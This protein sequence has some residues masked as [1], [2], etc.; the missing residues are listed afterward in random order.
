MISIETP[1]LV[2]CKHGKEEVFYVFINKNGRC[3]IPFSTWRLGLLMLNFAAYEWSMTSEEITDLRKKL[4]A[5]NA[6]NGGDLQT[7]FY[8]E[9]CKKN[10][11]CFVR[12][13]AHMHFVVG[14]LLGL[15]ISEALLLIDLFKSKNKKIFTEEILGIMRRDLSEMDLLKKS[16]Q[17]SPFFRDLALLIVINLFEGRL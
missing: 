15:S 12:N 6:D 9:M 7:G 5:A 16:D 2:A 8:F 17:V 1:A 13:D 10:K 11:G 3:S 4:D 14:D